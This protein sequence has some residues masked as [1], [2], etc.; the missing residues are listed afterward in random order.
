MRRA[1]KARRISLDTLQISPPDAPQNLS[2]PHDSLL[3]LSKAGLLLNVFAAKRK[4]SY[5]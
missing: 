4:L 5:L 1:Q 3:S 2:A